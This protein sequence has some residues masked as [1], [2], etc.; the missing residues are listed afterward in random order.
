MALLVP[1][2]E[3]DIGAPSFKALNERQRKFVM[4]L[5]KHGS[6]RGKRA[7]CA[8][9]AGYQGNDDALK[10]TAWRLFHDP[11][12]QQ[13]LH[14]ATVAYLG[15]QQLMA[16]EGIAEL[17]ETAKDESVKLRALLAIADRT[18]FAAVQQINVTKEDKNVTHEQ[19]IAEMVAM[20]VRNPKLLDSLAPPMRA[21]IESRMDTKGPA[22][23]IEAEFKEVTP[24]KAS[25]PDP[26]D[27]LLGL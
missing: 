24:A 3:Q 2:S 27:A 18:G 12:I 13:A 19:R 11:A 10:A 17:A 8:K 15:S 23:V 9:E 5:I 21:M 1:V 20:C 7:L 26:D 4:A 6:G 25:E 14:D 22:P 16:I